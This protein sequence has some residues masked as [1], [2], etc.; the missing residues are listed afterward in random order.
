[1][2]IASFPAACA[3]RGTCEALITQS[4]K[5]LR[6]SLLAFALLPFASLSVAQDA[7]VE[8]LKTF[9]FG[10]DRSI[11]EAVSQRVAEARSD[12]SLRAQ[13][14]RALAEVLQSDASFDAKQFACREMVFVG[15]EEQVPAL[16]SLL[17]D[18]KLGHYAV[19][20]LARIPSAKVN[21]ALRSALDEGRGPR[22]E[23]LVTL[24]ERGDQAA[25]P[26]IVEILRTGKTDDVLPAANALAKIGGARALEA[27]KDAYRK[28]PPDTRFGVGDALLAGA[29]RL[30]GPEGS[31]EA[32]AIYAILNEDAA[33]PL[34]RAGALRGIVATAGAGS[35]PEVLKALA[36][37]GSPRQRAAADLARTLPGPVS[38][39][40]LSGALDTLS[41]R[42]IVLL[43]SALADRG[44]RAAGR[45]VSNLATGADPAVRLA[46][47][48]A[49]GALGGE[50]SV[51][52]L[53]TAAVEGDQEL[54]EAAQASLA[55]LGDD[56]VSERLLQ[57]VATG[58]V[59]LR[60][61]AV[62]GIGRRRYVKGMPKLVAT[63]RSKE[64][65]L[66]QAAL[67][68]VRDLGGTELIT[69]LT[70]VLLATP[71]D[72]RGDVVETL[73]AV[74]RRGETEQQR[75]GTLL[76][77]LGKATRPAD[78][79]EL[80]AVLRQVGGAQ[81]L[82]AVRKASADPS[83][84]VRSGAIR[85]LSEWPTD[86][87]MAD[88]LRALKATQDRRQ[89]TLTLRGYIR[90][91]GLTETRPPAEMLKLYRETA[92]LATTTDEKRMILGG[93]GKVRSLG[94]LQL[95]GNYLR[96]EE[97]KAEA[98]LAVAEAARSTAGAYREET[99]TALEPIAVGGSTDEARN[100]AKGILDLIGKFG[101]FVT[102]WEV[103][104]AYQRAGAG[105][106]QLFDI[107]FPPEEASGAAAVPW[108]LVPAGGPPGQPC[109]IDLLA[110]LGG[111]QRVAYLRTAVWAEKPRE[112]ML[113]MGSDDGI[114][115]WSNG[116][117]VHANNTARA[118]A[119]G[120]DK[121]KV[122]LKAG[123]NDLLVKVTQ[124]VM[125]WGACARFTAAD[126]SPATGLK[127]TIP[128]DK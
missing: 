126:G 51:T 109:L 111:E 18:E 21:E 71:A 123:R 118:A 108:V 44:D 89:R 77:A 97:L 70:N 22:T 125:G 23:I 79:V 19:M 33:D 106:S 72:D 107:P 50:A 41:P 38:T 80:L 104:P 121:F 110:L 127:V 115:V 113:E 87:P 82:A 4:M 20:A 8:R 101:D 85:Q 90:M 61:Q 27:L 62:E 119:P 34:L 99:R 117:V 42:G 78:R 14:A 43:I 116:Q 100:R 96:D 95:A 103:S 58:P 75:T 56:A 10:E 69:P 98:E 83:P 1:M 31:S 13:V 55:R 12:P 29:R 68:V 24:G 11:V 3:R 6:V 64:P 124:N 15:S 76:Q 5:P 67:R 60:V 47:V 86:E 32:L 40:R 91:I 93:L 7:V 63:A 52:T 9:R 57:T 36:D 59:R 53:L 37:D 81:A 17:P 16:A 45:A 28:A 2:P 65:A 35:L 26:A 66:R 46:A 122:P 30:S 48:R 39:A 25:V 120:Q 92:A 128:S 74:A 54:R 114:K 73:S 112:V 94:A 105:H 88:L 84:E 49:L 102:A